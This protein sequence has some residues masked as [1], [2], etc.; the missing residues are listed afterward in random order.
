[1]IF[2]SLVI[3]PKSDTEGQRSDRKPNMWPFIHLRL[4]GI[5]LLVTITNITGFWSSFH[6]LWRIW[7]VSLSVI[8]YSWTKD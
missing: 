8:L 6:K 4:R 1:M 7:Q 3:S 2:H 5:E